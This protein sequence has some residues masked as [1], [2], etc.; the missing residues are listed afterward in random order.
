MIAA[1]AAAG[2]PYPLAGG[3]SELSHHGR[4]DGLLPGRSRP[5]KHRRRSATIVSRFL[6]QRSRQNLSALQDPAPRKGS[7]GGLGAT[8]ATVCFRKGR[9]H[10]YVDSRSGRVCDGSDR[11]CRSSTR[12]K[13]EILLVIGTSSSEVAFPGLI[14]NWINRGETNS[15]SGSFCWPVTASIWM[16]RTFTWHWESASL[17]RRPIPHIFP[18]Q[19]ALLA[20]LPMTSNGSVASGSFINLA[21]TL[22]STHVL[23]PN[24]LG[25]L[26]DVDRIIALS[27]GWLK[28]QKMRLSHDIS[29]QCKIFIDAHP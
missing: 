27:S 7:A 28:S 6:R 8:V 12:R 4:G 5:R 13:E 17:R 20:V 3:R 19:F 21:A 18:S 29:H 11:S 14:R 22:Q 2:D 24:G 23:P 16:A 25:L 15:W 1:V 10:D 26:F 9:Q